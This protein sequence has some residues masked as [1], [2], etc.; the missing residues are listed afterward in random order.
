MNYASVV[1]EDNEGRIYRCELENEGW[2]L[3]VKE[4]MVRKDYFDGK[5]VLTEDFYN[6]V[7]LHINPSWIKSFIEDVTPPQQLELF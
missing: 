7:F 2:S 5:L 1:N 4:L 6:T 3:G